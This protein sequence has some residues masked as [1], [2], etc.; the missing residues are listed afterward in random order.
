MM[1][2]VTGKELRPG[3]LGS[4]TVTDAVPWEPTRLGVI[5]TVRLE[6]LILE[7]VRLVVTPFSTHETMSPGAKLEPLMVSVKLVAPATA[8]AGWIEVT[9]GPTP[10]FTVMVKP[11][12]A[13]S[14][15]P[16]PLKS[17]TAISPNRGAL[18]A[19]LAPVVKVPFPLPR[20][21]AV[22]GLPP[23]KTSS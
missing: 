22:V 23:L 14:S 10:K 20:K 12:T 19:A 16:S 9:F 15:R 1:V 7:G 21:V 17:P 6:A 18:T 8:A 13:T 11:G 5:G 4:T 3:A 2:K